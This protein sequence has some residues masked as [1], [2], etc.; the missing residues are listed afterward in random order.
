VVR[1]KNVL[2]AAF[3]ALVFTAPLMAQQGAVTAVTLD[4]ALRRSQ[5]VAPSVI[6]AQG[7]IRTAEL[8]LRT[9]Q[10]QFIPNLVVNPQMSLSLSNGQ[11]RLDPITGEIISG[12]VRTPTYQFGASANYTIFD[13]FARNYNVKQQ[14]ANEAAADASLVTSRFASDLTTT[15][16]FFNALGTKQLV[17]VAQS[18]VNAAEGQLRL[19]T[20]KLHAG[21]GQLSDSLTALGGF[22]QAR[23][24]LLT[25]QSNLVVAESNLGRLIGVTGRVA[26]IDDSAFYRMAAPIDTGAV[27]Q[28]VMANA[29][30]LKSLEASLVASQNAWKIS[31][32]AYFPT[33][34][35]NAA[36]SW[37]GNWDTPHP[38]P[39]PS[40]PTGLIIR[41]S[42]NLTLSM[43]PWTSLARET[44]IE[45]AAIRISNA[46][47]Q[48][49]DQ[50]NLLAAQVSQA[51]ASLA[52]AQESINVSTAA[53]VAL[54]ENMRVVTERYRIGSA[55]ITEVLTAQQNL[56]SAQSNEVSAR[57]SYLLAKAQVEQILGRKL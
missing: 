30:A 13:G 43:N 24:Q 34:S 3:A 5:Q 27:R 50:R 44:Q 15:T 33:L 26:A 45:N 7:A 22:L 1:T 18:S 17:D 48:L 4:D 53:R 25:A 41:R 2:S 6:Q 52:N 10:W 37:T 16:A 9:A 19:A 23:L 32:A 47:A 14:R 21:S 20:A 38:A 51:F 54:D 12:S 39:S 29:P 56:T 35:V 36:Q 11:A 42:V 28:E 55:T 49:T 40:T 46:E 31:K 57:Y 8:G